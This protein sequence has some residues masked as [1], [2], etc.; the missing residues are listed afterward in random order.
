LSHAALVRVNAISPG[1]ILARDPDGATPP[2]IPAKWW[3]A[4][5]PPGAAALPTQS[6]M[7]PSIS[8]ATKPHSSTAR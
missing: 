1:V 3:C 2:S 6:P 7:R 8:P 4:G 5:C